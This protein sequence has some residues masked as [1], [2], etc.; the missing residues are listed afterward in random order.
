MRRKR[1]VA[2]RIQGEG[3]RRDGRE[4]EKEEDTKERR[5]ERGRD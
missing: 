4:E 1:R 5:G 3:K 2:M